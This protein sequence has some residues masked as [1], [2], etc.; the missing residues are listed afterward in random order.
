[1]GSGNG[2]GPKRH[3]VITRTS[4]DLSSVKPVLIWIPLKQF[5]NEIPLPFLYPIHKVLTH[6]RY[7][8]DDICKS[9]F[10]C[11]NGCIMIQILYKKKK[12]QL[13]ILLHW[14]R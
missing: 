11:E 14:V 7:F 9:I 3:Q 13:R 2:L 8:E 4:D 1:M 5:D 12:L 10:M 6:G